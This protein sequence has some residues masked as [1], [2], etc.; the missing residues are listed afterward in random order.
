MKV[1]I[2]ITCDN[3]EDIYTHLKVIRSQIAR[4]VRKLKKSS[5]IT[6]EWEPFTI[7][8]KDRYGS[9]RATVIDDSGL[10]KFI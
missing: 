1:Q 2:E 7:E 4:E 10:L 8:D 6:I 3:P 9:H 5:P